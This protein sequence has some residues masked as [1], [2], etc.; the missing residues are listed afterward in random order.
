M[1][2]SCKVISMKRTVKNHHTSTTG[3]KR[4]GRKTC[5]SNRKVSSVELTSL[6]SAKRDNII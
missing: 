3:G 4:D 1:N 2:M 6:T 5:E